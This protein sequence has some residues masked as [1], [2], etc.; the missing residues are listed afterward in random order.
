MKLSGQNITKIMVGTGSSSVEAK[1]V[2][3]GTGTSAVEAWTS[4]I[5]LTGTKDKDSRDQLLAALDSRGLDHTQIT[6]LPFRLD[7]SQATDLRDLFA[8]YT[9]LQ[10]VP[11]MDTSNVTIFSGL[12]MDCSS[13]EYI[14]ELDAGKVIET[15]EMFRNTSKLTSVVLRGVT[16]NVDLRDTKITASVADEFMRSAGEPSSNQWLYFPGTSAGCNPAIAEG[17]GWTVENIPGTT[18]DFVSSGEHTIPKP[19]WATHFDYYIC[20]GGGGG[21]SGGSLTGRGHGGYA[22]TINIGSGPLAASGGNVERDPLVVRVGSG[23]SGGVG[24]NN[25]SGSAGDDSWFF[26]YE[27]DSGTDVGMRGLGGSGGSGTSGSPREGE[28]TD[29]HTRFSN[30]FVGASSAG[31]DVNGRTPGGGGGGGSTGGLIGGGGRRGRD[32]GTGRVWVRLRGNG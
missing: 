13:L 18:F 19:S 4:T 3:V 12:F 9:S 8:G 5:K 26:P 7:T 14:P 24:S 10:V 1:K 30:T 16:D 21:A 32:G 11:E 17:K 2:M 20:G 29:T 6:E 31:V 22:S 15:T 27:R 23:G 28:G 25:V